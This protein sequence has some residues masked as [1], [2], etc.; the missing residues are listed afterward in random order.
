[1][2]QGEHNHIAAAVLV[3]STFQQEPDALIEL[4]SRFN[5]EFRAPVAF[6][7]AATVLTAVAALTQAPGL[8]RALRWNQIFSGGIVDEAVIRREI[9]DAKSERY[10][11]G[12]D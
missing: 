5:A 1:V 9:V 10:P 7:P 12:R 3:S 6:L 4:S 8:R 2:R 11:T